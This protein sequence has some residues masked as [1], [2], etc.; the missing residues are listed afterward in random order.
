MRW[1]WGGY[2][3][4]TCHGELVGLAG[5]FEVE[6]PPPLCVVTTAEARDTL[7]ALLVHVHITG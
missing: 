6:P 3:R 2:A 1:W 7:S 5:D 4:Q